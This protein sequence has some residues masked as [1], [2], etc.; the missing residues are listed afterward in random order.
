M[1]ATISSV[2]DL[3]RFGEDVQQT[4]GFRCWYR[5]HSRASYTLEPSAQRRG[6]T[7]EQ[8]RNLIHEFRVRAALRHTSVPPKS[9]WAAWLALA[10][11][12]G[13]PTRLMDWTFSPLIAAYFAVTGRDADEQQS[14]V[15][16]ALLP[17]ELNRHFGYEPY[18]YAIDAKTLEELINPAFAKKYESPAKVG[19]AMAVEADPR[20]QVQQGAFTVHGLRRPLSEVEGSENWL[21]RA[22]IPAREVASLRHELRILS[23]RKDSVFPDLSALASQV[24]SDVG[25]G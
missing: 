1:N 10:Q 14:A 3:I 19:A 25:A 2:A 5:G 8:E 16:W 15:I 23:I 6:R 17:S 22:E 7:E 21:F 13:L 24:V 12:Y 4:S 9:D 11:H 20:M 18:L